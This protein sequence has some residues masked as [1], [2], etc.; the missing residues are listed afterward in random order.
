MDVA[1]PPEKALSVSRRLALAALVP[2]GV[3]LLPPVSIPVR[4]V[5][6]MVWQPSARTLRPAGRW[7]ELGIRRLLV[8]W[9]AVDSQSFVPNAGLPPIAAELPDWERIATESWASEV[10]VGLAG[11]HGEAQARASV[12][13][14]VEQAR[15]LVAAVQRLP[16]R[17]RGWYFPL[18]V[19]PTWLPGPEWADSLAQL[20]RPL[21]I[22]AYDSANLGATALA[23]WIERWL[24]G[25]VGVF[26]Q[27]G[28]GVHARE[29]VVARHYLRVLTARLGRARVQVIAEAFRPASEGGFRSATAEEFLPQ[30]DAYE[31]WEILVFDGP[32]Y[33]GEA[34]ITDL[35]AQGVR[36]SRRRLS[37][38]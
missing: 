11:M 6:G 1:K 33:L 10:I 34:L 18:E 35:R 31:G 38:F 26:F 3:P 25:D 17:L 5:S 8:Q 19:D 13:L 20:P 30:I 4:R 29:P 21:W 14:L 7:D 9:T 23:D 2:C 28:V 16:L 32:H 22:S 12:G 37:D 15:A 27:D 36:R 24:P